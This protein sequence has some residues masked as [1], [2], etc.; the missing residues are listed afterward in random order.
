MEKILRSIYLLPSILKVCRLMGWITPSIF[1]THSF[2]ASFFSSEED[3]RTKRHNCSL[4]AKPNGIFTN[5]A[6]PWR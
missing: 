3:C 1:L 4:H 5:G 2:F 6:Q